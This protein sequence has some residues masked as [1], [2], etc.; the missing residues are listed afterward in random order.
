[1][2]CCVYKVCACVC[3]CVCVC[4]YVSYCVSDTHFIRRDRIHYPEKD[5]DAGTFIKCACVCVCVYVRA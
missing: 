2:C 1:V 3:V 4:E 5:N